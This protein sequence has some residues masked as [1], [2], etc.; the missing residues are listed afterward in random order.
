MSETISD[1]AS[2]RAR[3]ETLGFVLQLEQSMMAQVFKL[4]D[5]LWTAMSTDVSVAKL[6]QVKCLNA[7]SAKIKNINNNKYI[8]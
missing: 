4:L 2:S 3:L 1:N 7:S 8:L 6:E 5:E